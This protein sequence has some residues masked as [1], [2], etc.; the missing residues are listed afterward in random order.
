MWLSDGVG[1][2]TSVWHYPSRQGRQLSQILFAFTQNQFLH[3][4]VLLHGQPTIVSCSPWGA[5]K[6]CLHVSMWLWIT[7]HIHQLGIWWYS[8]Y[9]IHFH[10]TVI[11]PLLN[12]CRTITQTWPSFYVEP[13]QY[14][15]QT[16]TALACQ[17]KSQNST[18]P[19]PHRNT[20]RYSKFCNFFWPLL[21]IQ[22]HHTVHHSSTGAT[23]N[24]GYRYFWW[25]SLTSSDLFHIHW[26]N[27]TLYTFTIIQW[28]LG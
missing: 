18:S 25:N 23:T 11:E 13:S 15:H 4:P 7:L 27:V 17:N 3:C 21:N 2:W 9:I 19:V 6:T 24:V 14:Y 20:V 28:N 26:V 1:R 10:W 22:K 5:I 8:D 16:S 12:Q